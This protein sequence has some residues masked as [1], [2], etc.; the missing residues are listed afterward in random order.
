MRNGERTIQAAVDSVLAQS[1]PDFE[2]LIWNDAS[3][4]A[5]ERLIGNYSDPRIVA[6]G[7]T[8]NIGQG[9]AR[10]RAIRSAKG[11][12]LALIDADDAWLPIRLERLVA[13][14]E[15]TPDAMVF[16][17]L[18]LCH[19]TADGMVRWKRLRGS[20]AFGGDG[21]QAISVPIEKYLCMERLLIKPLIPMH[22]VRKTQANHGDKRF[23]EDTRFFLHLIAAGLE[24]KYH[25]GAMYLYRI[26]PGSMTSYRDR[27]SQ[28]LAVL[29]EVE[30][31]LQWSE[32]G[33]AAIEEKIGQ[34][35]RSLRYSEILSQMKKSQLLTWVRAVA[36]DPWFIPMFLKKV[37]HDVQASF[38][39]YL[40]GARKRGSQ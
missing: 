22:W 27:D 8:C 12:W 5:T 4:D 33:R 34:V 23:G 39:G 13:L 36:S 40:H 10:D 1:F 26:T 31:M 19:D 9:P 20:Q 17:D 25:P 11:Q 35:R 14:A 28:M 15:A 3:M 38:H 37:T 21:I 24:M 2:L 32:K 30:P 29:E 7:S 16:D 6:L 18:M